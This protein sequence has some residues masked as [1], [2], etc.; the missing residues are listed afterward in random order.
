VLGRVNAAW[1]DAA[2]DALLV[3][4]GRALRLASPWELVDA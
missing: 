4:A 3:V 1:A 2:E